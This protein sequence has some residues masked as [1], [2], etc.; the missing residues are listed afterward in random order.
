M[1]LSGILIPAG[2]VMVLRPTQCNE[3]SPM[4]GNRSP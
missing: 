2:E 4:S 1:T 3:N